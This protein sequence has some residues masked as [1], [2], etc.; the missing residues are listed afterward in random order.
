MAMHRLDTTEMAQHVTEY[1]ERTTSSNVNG[2]KN[3]EAETVSGVSVQKIFFQPD[4]DLDLA[5]RA[6]QPTWIEPRDVRQ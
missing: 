2:T 1:S 5:I 3:S 6:V 4:V